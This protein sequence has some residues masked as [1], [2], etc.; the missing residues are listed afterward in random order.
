MYQTNKLVGT[1]ISKHTLIYPGKAFSQT[2]GVG[3]AS[4][5]ALKASWMLPTNFNKTRFRKV[6]QVGPMYSSD[7]DQHELFPK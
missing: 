5:E 1:V 7:Q 2:Y 4:S 3:N 6:T